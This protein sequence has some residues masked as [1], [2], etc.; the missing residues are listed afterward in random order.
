MAR[1][2]KLGVQGFE[3]IREGSCFYVDKTGF[4]RDWRPA[5]DSVTLMCHPRR[6]GK[7]LSLDTVRC[8]LSRDFSD[9]GVY[10][11]RA[12]FRFRTRASV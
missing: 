6:F 11:K 7:T 8:F 12:P 10:A 2:M 5:Q 4:V 3:G 1:T 9:R